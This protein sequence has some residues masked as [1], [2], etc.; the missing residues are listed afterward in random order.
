M[1]EDAELIEQAVQNVLKGGLR[2]A[3]IMSEGMAKV[4]TTVMGEAV[5]TE[6]EK[7]TG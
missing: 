5:I 3:D 2:T 4:S 7:M 6:L 1:T